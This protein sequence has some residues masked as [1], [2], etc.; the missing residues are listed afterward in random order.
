MTQNLRRIHDVVVAKFTKFRRSTCLLVAIG[1]ACALSAAASAQ[2][3]IGPKPTAQPSANVCRLF[4]F[5]DKK[6]GPRL[7]HANC[8]NGGLVLGRITSF[9]AISNESLRA[10]LVDAR[11]GISRRVMLLVVQDDGKTIVEDLVGQLALA[12]GRGPTSGIDG[13]ELD[14]KHFAQTGDVGVLGRSEDR[15]RF[16]RDR[17]NV[18]DRDPLLKA[19]RIKASEQN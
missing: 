2:E 16:K 17:I 9:E 1:S 5:Q 7:L 4:S 3:Q 11:N 18:G 14:F 13:V 15:G 8:P 6:E 19:R 10:T 12:A